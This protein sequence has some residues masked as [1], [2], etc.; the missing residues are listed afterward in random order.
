MPKCSNCCLC[1]EIF[2]LRFVKVSK[3]FEICIK[4]LPDNIPSNLACVIDSSIFEMPLK[5]KFPSISS[6]FLHSSVC[7]N[8]VLTSFWEK[9]GYNFDAFS[10]DL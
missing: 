1:F 7:F 10:F 3:V 9:L 2:V 4:S 6:S 8:N 5:L